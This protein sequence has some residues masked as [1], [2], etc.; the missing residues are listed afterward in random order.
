MYDLHSHSLMNSN[1]PGPSPLF[2]SRNT[3]Y[4]LIRC[5]G[6][7]VGISLSYFGHVVCH[8][9]ALDIAL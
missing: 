1:Y 8:Y 4:K 6:C 9:M 3:G 2:L 7:H 5:F